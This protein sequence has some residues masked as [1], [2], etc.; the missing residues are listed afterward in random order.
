MMF[1]SPSWFPP[2]FHM[3][4]SYLSGICSNLS[5]TQKRLSLTILYRI[6]LALTGIL[7]CFPLLC[8]FI[9]AYPYLSSCTFLFLVP[10]PSAPGIQKDPKR[11]GAEF[12]PQHMAHCLA[13]NS[14]VEYLRMSPGT[15]R[16]AQKC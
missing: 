11:A 14:H 12:Y 15:L 10:V 9:L 5:L 1:P 6:V 7:D 13:Q 3:A 8:F 2:H 16:N 4:P